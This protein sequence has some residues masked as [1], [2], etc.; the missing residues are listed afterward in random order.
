MKNVILS[1][2]FASSLSIT[3]CNSDSS[4]PVESKKLTYINENSIN[5]NKEKILNAEPL[6]VSALDNIVISADKALASDAN[7]VTNKPTPGPSGNLH[8]YLSI[9][10]YW[11]P[12]PDKEDG[13]PWIRKD[14]EVNP[15]TRGNNTDQQ[16][17]STLLTNLDNLNL[18]YIYTE[19]VHYLEKVR[20]LLDIWLV[21]IDT[22]MN[23]HLNY[24]Q[25]VPGDS[26][27]RC[28]GI[29][30]LSQ[31]SSIVTSV[32]LIKKAG[33]A[34]DEFII[35]SQQWL[36]DYLTWL[37]T[38]ELGIEESTR[39]NNHGTWYDVQVLGLM[40]HLNQIDA[41]EAYAQNFKTNRIEAQIEPD[42]SQPHE[43]SR[44]KS[45]N[46]SSMNLEA[47]LKV[48]DLSKRIDVDLLEYNGKDGE[49]IRLA[50]EFMIPYVEGEK[51]WEYEQIGDNTEA[52]NKKTIPALFIANAIFEDKIASET[53][54]DERSEYIGASKVLSF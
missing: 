31:V 25:G 16:R 17:T 49:S 7:P 1:L 53:L 20:D 42:G 27:G 50:A 9:G 48:A 33:I 54:L 40:I 3:G 45:I 23:P 2:L 18:A 37:E 10:P 11:W 44:T 30:E 36:T 19:Q 43:L 39:E 6:Y 28:F 41:A 29:I 12:D 22:K 24:A 21:S 5:S 4:V 14:G 35:A 15:M 52:F 47:F 34:S 46:Y 26:T 38:S 13:L 51:E 8:D 32:E